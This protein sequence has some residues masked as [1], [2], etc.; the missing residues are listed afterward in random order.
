MQAPSRATGT[1]MVGMKVARKF[2]RKTNITMKTSTIASASVISTS[3][4]EIDT[5]RLVS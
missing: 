4:I 5:N 2:C 1:T 3:S